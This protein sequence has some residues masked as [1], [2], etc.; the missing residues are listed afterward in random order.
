MTKIIQKWKDDK[1][2]DKS[3]CIHSYSILLCGNKSMA[4]FRPI[5]PML[6]FGFSATIKSQVL[7]VVLLGLW[8]II[9]NR[10]DCVGGP[11][12]KQILIAAWTCAFAWW[13]WVIWWQ[14]GHDHCRPMSHH[15]PKEFSHVGL[16]LPPKSNG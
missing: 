16:G 14:Q 3:N 12:N 15:F 11:L 13:W 4:W 7:H 1:P 6:L 8:G 5:Q 2:H 9:W 10:S